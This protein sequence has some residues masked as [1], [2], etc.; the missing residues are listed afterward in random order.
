M[1]P[2]EIYKKTY[3]APKMIQALLDENFKKIG[4]RSKALGFVTILERELGLDLSELREKIDEYYSASA[5]YSEA[6][7]IKEKNE[8]TK[9]NPMLV[10]FLLVVL[11]LGIGYYFYDK[12]GIAGPKAS[13]TF[14]QKS[15]KSATSVS[16]T[17]ANTSSSS[18]S[19]EPVIVVSSEQNESNSSSSSIL[20]I[21]TNQESNP[22]SSQK[23]EE[24]RT[25]SFEPKAPLHMITI[26]PRKKLWVGIVYLDN[27]K[28]RSF[29]TSKPIELNTSR[30]QL[31]VTGHGV[32]DIDIDGQVQ[33][34]ND[35]RKLRFLYRAGELEKIDAKIF[36][37]YN[38]GKNW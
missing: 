17:A 23:S 38:R 26:V 30:D 29:V 35:R 34:Y 14:L 13:E 33:K 6:F 4:N 8:P 36:K 28:R 32:L 22:S 19:S 5:H 10:L 7:A 31:I 24:N 21:Q 16:L 37:Q 25:A 20:S 11:V 3:I 15:S 1:D 18:Q 2:E 27:Y 12:N 9:K